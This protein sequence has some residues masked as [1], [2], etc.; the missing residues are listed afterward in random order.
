[1]N[2][3]WTR[4]EGIL[5]LYAYCQVPF[6]KASN[7]NPLIV[8][9]AQLINRTPASVKMKIGNFGSFDA[10]LRERGIVGLSGHS[11]LDEELWN[12]FYGRWDILSEL[13]VQSIW[14]LEKR[15]GIR[16][17]IELEMPV[18]ED[19]EQLTKRRINQDF[20]RS[21]V[22]SS[23]N[24]KCCV[25]GLHC[26]VLLEAAHIIAWKDDP[27]LRTDPTNGL[28]LNTLLHRAYDNFML[29]ITPHY[30]IEF[31]KSFYNA[32]DNND[33][34]HFM[35]LKQGTTIIVPDRFLPNPLFLE[36]HYSRYLQVNI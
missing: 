18:G 16:N 7:N 14:D 17:N 6:N 20:F 3:N 34:K 26:D 15:R 35:D 29:S 10:A 5:A 22:L 32:V 36:K 27:S 23:Y 30:T 12:E 2:K 21:A 25:S 11:K 9:I 8:R 4:E 33:L 24:N 13:A 1:M 31:S 19:I 28:C